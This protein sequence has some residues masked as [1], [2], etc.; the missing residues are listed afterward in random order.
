MLERLSDIATAAKSFKKVHRERGTSGFLTSSCA[1]ALEYI[2]QRRNLGGLSQEQ[3]QNLFQFLEVAKMV[4]NYYDDHELHP[5]YRDVRRNLRGMDDGSIDFYKDFHRRVKVLETTR[6]D[7]WNEDV[8][9]NEICAYRE[10]V[11]AVYLATACASA[12]I[13]DSESFL[14]YEGD[15][16]QYSETAPEWFIGLHKGLVAL[17]VVDDMIG[18]RGD[19]KQRRP[20]FFTCLADK[21]MINE[22]SRITNNDIDTVFDTMRTLFDM[23]VNET[24]FYLREDWALITGIEGLIHVPTLGRTKPALIAQRLSG[25]ELINPRHLEE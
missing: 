4:N 15:T 20:S 25:I 6:P 7:P 18:W 21:Q 2:L 12:G 1:T 14:C 23:Y 19:V 9:V 13:S 3:I 16:P 17:Q 11:N 24:K 5:D 10:A 8:D 22:P